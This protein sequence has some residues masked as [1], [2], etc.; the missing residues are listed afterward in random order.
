MLILGNGRVV[1]RNPECPYMEEGA[2]AI[3]GKVICKVGPTDELKKAYPDAEFIDAKG[4]VIMPAFINTHEH[5]YSSFAR[6]LAINGYNP[7]GLLSI[8][9]GM[10]W[11]LDRNLTLNDTYLI[12]RPLIIVSFKKV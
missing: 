12:L 6:G 10:W 11:T 8:L 5:I 4:G 1:T 3:D 9:E 2:V 7:T